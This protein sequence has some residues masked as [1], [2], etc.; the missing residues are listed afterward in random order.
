MM[1]IRYETS[2]NREGCKVDIR[3]PLLPGIVKDFLLLIP[4]LM[5]GVN[6]VLLHD[7]FG[8]GL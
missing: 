4:N 2:L 1:R 6:W 8:I 5:R 3:T 7:K